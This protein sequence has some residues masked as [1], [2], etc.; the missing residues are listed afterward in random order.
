MR[1]GYPGGFQT[2]PYN[3][4]WFRLFWHEDDAPHRPGDDFWFGLMARCGQVTDMSL[5]RI[6]GA[7]STIFSLRL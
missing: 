7:T 1:A 4:F 5:R 6:Q 2:R 3:N